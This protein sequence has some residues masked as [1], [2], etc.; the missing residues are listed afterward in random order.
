MHIKSDDLWSLKC[1]RFEIKTWIR[2]KDHPSNLQ[3]P[4]H[5][6]SGVKPRL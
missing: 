2:S 1:K 5:H 6:L 4:P 3:S